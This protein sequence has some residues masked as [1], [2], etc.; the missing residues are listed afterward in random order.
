MF[1]DELKAKQ[2]VITPHYG[3]YL[4]LI[5]NESKGRIAD[6]GYF[7]KNNI[8]TIPSIGKISSFLLFIIRVEAIINKKE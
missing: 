1:L 3:E 5:S 2:I 4:R 8:S 6:A 7:N